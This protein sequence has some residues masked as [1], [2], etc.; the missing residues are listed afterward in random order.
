MTSY[1][2]TIRFEVVHYNSVVAPALSGPSS[3]PM[4]FGPFGGHFIAKVSFL[5]I[6]QLWLL[7]FLVGFCR[8][9]WPL[10]V[11]CRSADAWNQHRF[12]AFIDFCA[13]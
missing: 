10:A 1:A 12:E 4:H 5:L 9:R 13:V 8:Q 7:G 6:A 11:F 3:N 2:L